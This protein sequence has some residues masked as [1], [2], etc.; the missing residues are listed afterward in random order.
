VK[1]FGSK[2]F[3]LIEVMIAAAILAGLAVAAM[4]MFKTQTTAQKTVEKK[5]EVTVAA[6]QM[7]TILSTPTN[8]NQTFAGVNSNGGT[9]PALKK[10]IN[11]V[12]EDVFVTGANQPEGI[13]IK[14]Y[15][16]SKAF[17]NLLSN[18]TMLVVTF[19]KGKG[20]LTDEMRKTIKLIITETAGKVTT[21]YATSSGTEIWAYTADGNSIFYNGGSVA[22]GNATPQARLDVTGEV[23]VGNSGMACTNTNEGSMRYNPDPSVKNM[24]ICDGT[25][26][27]SLGGT[28][29]LTSNGWW[30]FGGG[31]MIQWG[32]D[33]VRGDF[34]NHTFATPFPNACFI[35]IVTTWGRG[36]RGANG[37]NHVQFCNK[38]NFTATVELG[39]AAAGAGWIAIGF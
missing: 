4:S 30:T 36:N 32:H 11:G 28:G 38:N 14:S 10:F 15:E 22:V 20:T 13:K 8:C 29:S 35:T 18:E 1:Q 3:G 12:F 24:E 33:N 25:N 19:Q 17:P 21:C 7:R 23:R 34:S 26:W 27:K 2:G 5:Y 37:H 6:Q 31:L 9:V 16:L 39:P